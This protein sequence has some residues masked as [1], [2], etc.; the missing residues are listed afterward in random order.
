[1]Y[2]NPVYQVLRYQMEYVYQ[3]VEMELLQVA[4]VVMMVTR[5]VEM[6]VVVLVWF[7][8]DIL[9]FLNLQNAPF[10]LSRLLSTLL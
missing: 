8:I 6:D 4:R 3:N 5:I 10:L 1:M 2:V 9:A 7:R